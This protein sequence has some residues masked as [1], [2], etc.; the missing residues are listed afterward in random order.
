MSG[1]RRGHKYGAKKATCQAGHVHDSRKESGRCD[2]LHLLQR[3][4]QVSDLRVQ[5]QFWFA[6][7]GVQI[8]H[9]NGR[10]VGMKVD[11]VY[12]EG[13]RRVAEDSKG[14]VVRDWPLRAAIFRAL[15]PEVEL[16]ET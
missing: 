3:V 2:E 9:A 11:F 14:F 4:G 16:R 13:A 7:N 15:Y 12:L 1:G 5:E 6:I 10:R 8:K